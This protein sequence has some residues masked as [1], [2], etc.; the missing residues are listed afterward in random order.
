MTNQSEETKA[1][2]A[3]SKA[4][5][6]IDEQSGGAGEQTKAMRSEL[7]SSIERTDAA[8]RSTKNVGS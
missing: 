6:A 7:Y 5:A 2:P 4:D 3:I 1:V 8:I